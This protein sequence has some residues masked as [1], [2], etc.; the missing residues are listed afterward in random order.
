[1]ETILILGELFFS[2]SHNGPGD[3]FSPEHIRLRHAPEVVDELWRT[4]SNGLA[5][6]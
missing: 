2:F 5:R 3:P 1:M 6:I 4:G